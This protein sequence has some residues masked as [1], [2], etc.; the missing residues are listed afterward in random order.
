MEH[1]LTRLASNLTAAISDVEEL[2]SV[3]T[4]LVKR[5]TKA[6]SMIK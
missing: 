2:N 1:C 4:G 3:A 5:K 6:C